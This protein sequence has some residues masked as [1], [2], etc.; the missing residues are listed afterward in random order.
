MLDLHFFL[1]VGLSNLI[2]GS[3]VLLEVEITI[4]A[5][6]IVSPTLFQSN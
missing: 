4:T 6:N 2:H 3:F 5:Q 1:L